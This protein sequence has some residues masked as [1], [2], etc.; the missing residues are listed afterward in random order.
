MESKAGERM[1]IMPQR[2]QNQLL[3][4]GEKLGGIRTTLAKMESTQENDYQIT[5]M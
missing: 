4:R 1:A 5:F 2:I 3:S